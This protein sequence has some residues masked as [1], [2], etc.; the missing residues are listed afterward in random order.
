MRRSEIQRIER[1]AARFALYGSLVLVG[2]LAWALV[3][4]SNRPPAPRGTERWIDL[5]YKNR[6]E[7]KLL[8]QYVR[9]DTSEATGD[10][11]AGAEFLARQFEAAGIRTEIEV[12]SGK[13]ANL[14]AW[15]P[16]Q[17]PHPLVLHNHIDV[18]DVDPAEWFSPPFEA[19]IELP[20]IYG[21]GVFDMKS[22]AIAQ[23]M[24]MIEL[25]RSGRPLSRSVLFLA[26]SSEENGSRLGV[27]WILHHHPELV[28][29]FWAVLTEGGIVEARARDDIKY[30]GTEVAQKRVAEMTVCSGERERLED[31][32]AY[33]KQRGHTE[34]DLHLI[35]EAR[36]LFESYGPTRD[37]DDLRGLLAHPEK[38][39]E[40]IAEFRKLSDYLR[41]MY[42]NEV[43][44]FG[45]HE[46]QGGGYELRLMLHLLPGQEPTP[47]LVDGLV[48]PWLIFG[49]PRR[50]DVPPAAPHGSPTDHPVFRGILEAIHRDFPD[51]PSGPYFQPWSMTDSRFFRAAGV[52][53]YGFSPFLILTTDTLQ[54]DRAN[55]RIALPGFVQGVGLYT[56]LLRRLVSDT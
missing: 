4:I 55:E 10:E 25:K 30:W 44:P 21:R 1:G 23:M 13:H 28:K 6:P 2:V 39:L 11:V 45:I 46:A 56:Q 32:V 51:A 52:P 35:P 16:G 15:L 49:L 36:A 31:I 20:W 43:V 29:S 33:L 50:L 54:V 27:R 47:A 38:P 26:T 37:R 41:S 34:T 3:A 18:Q 48:P 53:S 19:R 42:R 9:I 7:V 5:D 22:V 8:Q 24:A 40:D 12:L 14:Y 17:D